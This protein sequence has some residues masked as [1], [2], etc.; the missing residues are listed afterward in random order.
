MESHTL[1][2]LTALDQTIFKSHI[3]Q[4]GEQDRFPKI[5]GFLEAT[6]PCHNA[7]ISLQRPELSSTERESQLEHRNLTRQAQLA[8]SFFFFFAITATRA[9]SSHL[10]QRLPYP[11]SLFGC[12]EFLINQV[13]ICTL[14]LDSLK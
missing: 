7:G 11:P 6:K 9:I 2:Q 13:K 5:R 14:C 3:P 4:R 12:L 10:G 8:A 1:L